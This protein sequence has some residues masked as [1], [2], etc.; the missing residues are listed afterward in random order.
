[1]THGER[2]ARG[3]LELK[4]RSVLVMMGIEHQTTETCW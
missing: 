3:L 2:A 4:T 1:M